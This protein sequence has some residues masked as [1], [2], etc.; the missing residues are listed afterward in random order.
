MLFISIHA[1]RV[2]S[3][4]AAHEQDTACGISIHAPLVGSDAVF[5][6]YMQL[7]TKSKREKGIFVLF[8]EKKYNDRLNL[9]IFLTYFRAF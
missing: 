3:D 2:G 4:A 1:P 7:K 6:Y 8:D 9:R 5:I